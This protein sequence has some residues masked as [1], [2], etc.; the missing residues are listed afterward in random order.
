[1]EPPASA[2]ISS[3]VAWGNRAPAHL[4]PP[5]ADG[6]DGELGGVSAVADGDP[7]LVVG[8]VVDPIG[9]GLGVLAQVPVGEV[10]HPDPGRFALRGPFGAPVRVVADQLLLLGVDTDHRFVVV[11]E[12]LGQ[13]VEV[14]ELGVAVGM[15]ASLRHLGVGL[16]RIAETMQQAQHRPPRHR[17]PPRTSSSASFVDD[18]D[19]HRSNDI[20][21]PRVSG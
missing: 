7:A 14:T 2:V 20:G 16:Q 9:D 11:D 21:F 18:F 3:R 1:L 19:V 6:L 17:E 4:V 8:D 13:V 12:V 15:L 10:V 5:A